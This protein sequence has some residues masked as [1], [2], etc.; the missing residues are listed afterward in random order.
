MSRKCLMPFC[1]VTVNPSG[2]VAPCCKYNLNKVD[3]DI[4]TETLYTKNLEELFFQPSMEKIRQQFLNDE[5]PEACKACWDEEAS[6]IIS[7]RQHRFNLS[8]LNS[9][10]SRYAGVIEN[11]KIVS[12]DLKF[13]SLCN[14]KC[15]ICGPYCSSTWLKESLD[16]GQYHEHT[17]G[18]F[19]SY[20]QRKFVNK[21]ENFSIFK[22]LIPNLHV[23]E[24]YGGEP[25]MQP[26]H[27]R[28]M[29]IL[30]EHPNIADCKLQLY[31][32]T[33]G[34]Q[35]DEK[36][37][38][39]WDQMESVYLNI[40]VDDINERFNYQRHPAKWEEVLNNILKYKQN[41][42]ENIKLN[43]Y[44]TVSLYNIFY[45]DEL[46][47]FNSEVMKCSIR[48]NLLHWPEKMSIKHLPQKLKD[49]I[50]NKIDNLDADS[51]SYIKEENGVQE[52]VNFMMNNE[53]SNVELKQFF[54]VTR[55]HDTYRT[56]SFEGTFTD[57]WNMFNE[58]N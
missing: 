5:E 7:I 13:S 14:L 35:F 46:L 54:E 26:E 52:V 42:K 27:K 34:T 57:Y 3:N 21:E 38:K 30:E 31:Y 50:K 32:N 47:K 22:K 24:F 55:K 29:E 8:R 44:C 6:G 18:I 56:E 23:I 33:N 36:A 40:S 45:L 51:L 53:G 4:D 19:S 2:S 39:I 10:K 41:A 28:I 20:S 9:N 11:P 15:R 43:L 25:F 49:H 1:N 16:T 12:L 17:I 37:L 48:F 58:C